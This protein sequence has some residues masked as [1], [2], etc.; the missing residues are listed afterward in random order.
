MENIKENSQVLL[1]IA[2]IAFNALI[3]GFGVLQ[4]FTNR[5]QRKINDDLEHQIKELKEF[6]QLER[7]ETQNVSSEQRV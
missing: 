7:S 4:W 2:N 1:I 6:N 5:V 3:L